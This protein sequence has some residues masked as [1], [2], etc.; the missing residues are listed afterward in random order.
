MNY[1]E[2]MVEEADSAMKTLFIQAKGMYYDVER[3]E[4]SIQ[5]IYR[6]IQKGSEI[7]FVDIGSRRVQPWCEGR[8]IGP[9]IDRKDLK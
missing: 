6:C 8:F 9:A 5:D 3:M 7:E 2:E 4:K 1:I